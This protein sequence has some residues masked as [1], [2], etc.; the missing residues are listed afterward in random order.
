MFSEM[1]SS[2]VPILVAAAILVPAAIAHVAMFAESI[3]E[4]KWKPARVA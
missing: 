2:Y 3:G 1:I 4:R